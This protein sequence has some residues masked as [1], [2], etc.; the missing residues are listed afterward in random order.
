MSV[1][2]AVFSFDCLNNSADK[3]A[4]IKTQLLDLFS[5]LYGLQKML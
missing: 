3:I 2:D 5:H 1:P 4:N